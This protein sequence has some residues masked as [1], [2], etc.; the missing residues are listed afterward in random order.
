MTRTDRRC[1]LSFSIEESLDRYVNAVEVEREPDG[2]WHPS[3][4]SGCPRQALYGFRGVKATNPRDDRSKRILRVGHLLHE[5]VQAAILADPEVEIFYPEIS[6]HDQALN[7]VGH[8]DGLMRLKDGS[9]LLLEFK[10]INSMAFKYRDLPKPE[11][12]TQVTAYMKA[13]RDFGCVYTLPDGTIGNIAPLGEKLR[14]ARI[15]YVSKDDMRVEECAFFYS[16]DKEAALVERVN[17]LELHRVND[18]YPD[19]LPLVADKKNGGL[20]RDWQ[21]GYCPW[22]DLC[23]KK[24]D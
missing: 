18:T 11:H 5:F 2:H 6:L 4:I 14:S 9:W 22:Q 23:W 20:K 17:F 16:D 3:S 12:V 10:T 21:C 1:T 24:E 19:R 8:A 13:V 7:I 15:V